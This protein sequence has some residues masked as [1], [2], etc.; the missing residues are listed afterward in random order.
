MLF[1]YKFLHVIAMI[2]T[3]IFSILT[4]SFVP[5]A[6]VGNKV[7]I[8][9][10][11][12]FGSSLGFSIYFVKLLKGKIRKEKE[13]KLDNTIMKLALK[14]GGLITAAELA[15]ATELNVKEAAELLDANYMAGLC[16]KRYT[17]KGMIPV[18]E[19]KGAIS[20]SEK[21]ASKDILD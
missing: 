15:A 18:Y 19:Y 21:R 17:E 14:K 13:N 8:V 6:I 20:D 3:V 7:L 10:V 1:W 16:G 4:A 9:F 5:G 2:A 11:V 12:L